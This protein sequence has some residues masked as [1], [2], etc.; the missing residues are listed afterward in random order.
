MRAKNGDATSIA[1][2]SEQREREISR[3]ET[4]DLVKSAPAQRLIPHPSSE[5]LGVDISNEMAS[6]FSFDG[7][8]SRSENLAIPNPPWADSAP[9]SRSTIGICKHLQHNHRVMNTYT[10]RGWG[11]EPLNR[12]VGSRFHDYS[13]RIDTHCDR[14]AVRILVAQVVPRMLF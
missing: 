10:K 13:S 11:W 9:A 6:V 8:R 12:L 5:P 7:A 1:I 2:L 3:A 14:A 4:C